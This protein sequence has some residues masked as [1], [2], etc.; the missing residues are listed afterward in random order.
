MP[1]QS[2]IES[3]DSPYRTYSPFKAYQNH[4]AAKQREQEE[5][6]APEVA[7]S[8]YLQ[9]RAPDSHWR[10]PSASPLPQRTQFQIQEYNSGNTSPIILQR[11][12]HQQKQQQLAKEAEESGN[13]FL[14]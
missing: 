10:S 14:T 2:T 1:H 12:Y 5:F 13:F 6:Q 8:P 11:Y 9:R 7:V 4:L 3:N